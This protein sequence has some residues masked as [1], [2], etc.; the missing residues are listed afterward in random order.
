MVQQIFAGVAHD[1]LTL[2]QVARRLQQQGVPTPSG[3]G[4]WG[5]S[6]VAMILRNPAYQ[7]TA[8]YGKIR[9]WGDDAASIGELVID[10]RRVGAEY[11][12]IFRARCRRSGH[13]RGHA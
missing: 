2:A 13:G 6:T 5:S 3:R 10:A 9:F 11:P 1:R 7:G 12:R 4:R 8:G